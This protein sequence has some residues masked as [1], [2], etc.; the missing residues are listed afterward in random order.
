MPR[1]SPLK[2]SDHLDCVR[3]RLGFGTED[4]GP[5]E[6]WHCVTHEV[7]FKVPIPPIKLAN[8]Y[9][10]SFT[11][12]AKLAVIETTIPQ[13]DAI[14][15]TGKTIA[16]FGWREGILKAISV[17]EH[18]LKTGQLDNHVQRIRLNSVAKVLPNGQVYDACASCGYSPGADKAMWEGVVTAL[19]KELGTPPGA[20]ERD[21]VDS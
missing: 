20:P 21:M 12:D 5:Y 13:E 11:P 15:E 14:A 8:T 6:A 9:I 4:R 2:P 10:F 17:I 1:I 7:D 16:L 19:D 18:Y 3:R